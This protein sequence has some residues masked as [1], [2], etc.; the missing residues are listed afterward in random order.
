M[1]P[2]PSD[3]S[4]DVPIFETYHRGRNRVAARAAAAAALG[5]AA[6][7][8]VRRRPS[9]VAIEGPSMAPTLVPGDWCL[10]VAPRRWRRGDVVVVEHPGRPGYEMVKRLVGL[11]GDDVDGRRLGPGEHWIEGD[12][13]SST[14][15]R[16]F[17]PVGADALRARVLLIYWPPTRRRV[18]RSSE[19]RISR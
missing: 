5:V 17:G 8:I 9:R 7:T 14:D 18:L 1:G 2:P 10:V 12:H 15:S 3:P 13:P 16:S 19:R 4:D 11:P 6:W